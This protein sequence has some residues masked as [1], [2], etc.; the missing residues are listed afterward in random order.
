MHGPRPSLTSFSTTRTHLSELVSSRCIVL[1]GGMITPFLGQLTRFHGQSAT[2]GLGYG[3]VN[4]A[5]I[6]QSHLQCPGH[7]A[8]RGCDLCSLDESFEEE[9]THVQYE[10]HRGYS[11]ASKLSGPPGHQPSSVFRTALGVG[12]RCAAWSESRWPRARR[13]I[14]AR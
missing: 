1:V 11:P 12:S 7:Q 10:G 4:N 9:W 5:L 2:H 8:F 13:A 14:I 3:C 6:L